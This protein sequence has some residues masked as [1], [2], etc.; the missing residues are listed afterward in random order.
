MRKSSRLRKNTSW[1]RASIR[2]I[3][4]AFVNVRAG[5]YCLHAEPIVGMQ[6]G[7]LLVTEDAGQTWHTLPTGLDSLLALSE[8]AA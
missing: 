1:G 8:G 4:L 5:I 7:G 6:N 3:R 2:C